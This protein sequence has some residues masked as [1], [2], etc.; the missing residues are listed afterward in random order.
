M[1]RHVSDIRRTILGERT[2]PRKHPRR[3]S[4]R[5]TDEDREVG[6]V[7]LQRGVVRGDELPSIEFV[8]VG[9]GGYMRGL[10]CP[11]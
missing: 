5:L 11:R 4:L 3:S 10:P 8:H 2:K 6:V 9:G 7:F 1:Q